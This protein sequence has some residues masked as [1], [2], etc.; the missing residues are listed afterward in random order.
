MAKKS[1][2]IVYRKIY[3]N[4]KLHFEWN[5]KIHGRNC[6]HIQES[7]GRVKFCLLNSLSELKMKALFVERA[8][9][10]SKNRLVKRFSAYLFSLSIS[11]T[12]CFF[13]LSHQQIIIARWLCFIQERWW[14]T[15]SNFREK[16]YLFL[17]LLEECFFDSSSSL[18]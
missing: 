3:W 6:V 13:L 11:G 12:T 16:Y 1:K 10:N 2:Q 7:T 18:F 4:W 14:P 9:K 5:W 8:K 17:L 15:I